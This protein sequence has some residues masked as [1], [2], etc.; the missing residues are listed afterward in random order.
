MKGST[1][2]LKV[3]AE[4]ATRLELLNDIY[5]ASTKRFLIDSGLKNGMHVADIGCGPGHL[6]IWFAQQV[7]PKGL[8]TAI[9]ISSEQLALAKQKAKNAGI[10]NIE[11]YEC[12]V[13]NL[14]SLNKEFDLVYSKFLLMHLPDYYNSLKTILSVVKKGGYIICEELENTTWGSIPFSPY[15]KQRNEL[16]LRLGAYKKLNY[17]MAFELPVL[18]HKL[19]CNNINI[20]LD[21]PVFKKHQRL[22]HKLLLQE[23]EE[24]FIQAQLITEDEYQFLIKNINELADD[25]NF[26]LIGAR[27][28]QVVGQKI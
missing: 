12:D 19:N 25:E 1:Y 28:L 5:E 26:H 6:L 24:E 4:G 3:G 13:H 14:P 11:F 20:S 15:I 22:Y 16:L 10:S 23:L 21:Q 8:V 2:T 18:L 7:G 9:D 17:N 27:K